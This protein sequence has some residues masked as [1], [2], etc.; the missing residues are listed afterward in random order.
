MLLEE[1][2]RLNKK[3][4]D[5]DQERVEVIG[6][7][8]RAENYIQE[9]EGRYA[10]LEES[11]SVKQSTITTQ[12]TSGSEVQGLRVELGELE[13]LRR[14]EVAARDLRIIFLLEEINR[15]N[16]KVASLTSSESSGASS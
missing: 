6:H 11:S 13:N 15:L 5:I 9:L 8:V 10:L 12:S 3:C 16:H 7:L 1:I 4:A 14:I 2:N